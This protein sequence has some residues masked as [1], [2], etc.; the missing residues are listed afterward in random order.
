MNREGLS[1]VRQKKDV[2]AQRLHQYAVVDP[3]GGE[4]QSVFAGRGQMV[5]AVR[6]GL[7]EALLERIR[8]DFA[9]EMAE[10]DAPPF[11]IVGALQIILNFNVHDHRVRLLDLTDA[12]ELHAV[13]E[14]GGYVACRGVSREIARRHARQHKEHQKAAGHDQQHEHRRRGQ[15]HVGHAAVR[16]GDAWF[17]GVGVILRDGMAHLHED[18]CDHGDHQEP[19]EGEKKNAVDGEDGGGQHHQE[20]KHGQHVMVARSLQRE[21]ADDHAEQH[22]VNGGDQEAPRDE[23]VIGKVDEDVE[24]RQVVRPSLGDDELDPRQ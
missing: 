12:A 1:A 16:R 21:Q 5:S 3:A 17:L 9:V 8:P 11:Q 24:Q 19:C 20:R 14:A 2:R 4:C 15:Q 13:G 23:H 7:H 6:P 10:G 22:Q 18:E